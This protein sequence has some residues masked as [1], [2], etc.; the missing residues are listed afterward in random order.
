[1]GK[2]FYGGRYI[3]GSTFDEK[4]MKAHTK[5]GTLDEFILAGGYTMDDFFNA[6]LDVHQ[7]DQDEAIKAHVAKFTDFSSWEDMVR[8]AIAECDAK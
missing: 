1:M 3:V 4:F 6:E 7:I 2:D 8:C 5:F